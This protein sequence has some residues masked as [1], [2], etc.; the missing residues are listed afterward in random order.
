MAEYIATED[1]ATPEYLKTA[2]I[3]VGDLCYTVG[4]FRFIFGK[5]TNLPLVHSGNIALFPPLGE[6]SRSGM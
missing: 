1:M 5:K 6:R 2:E 4:L 3:D